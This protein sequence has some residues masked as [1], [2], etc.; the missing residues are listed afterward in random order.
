MNLLSINAMKKN[1]LFFMSLLAGGLF[2][3]SSLLAN[4]DDLPSID[5]NNYGVEQ[6]NRTIKG[7]VT[8]QTGSPLWRYGESPKW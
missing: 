8:D 4:L 5:L 6:A 7:A 2:Y 3:S 1:S